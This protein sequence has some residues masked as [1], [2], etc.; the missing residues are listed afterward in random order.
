M[1]ERFTRFTQQLTIADND[2]RIIV[3]NP[4]VGAYTKAYAAY[5]E[6]LDRQKQADKEAGELFAAACVV[7]GSFLLGSIGNVSMQMIAKR[8]VAQ[9]AN[10]S[11][12][13]SYAN[14]F[15]I[16]RKNEGVAFAVGK[17]VDAATG[18][19]KFNAEKIATTYM[20]DVSSVISPE[21]LVQPRW[22]FRTRYGQRR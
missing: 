11:L 1:S 21:P 4:Y 13:K 10:S 17:F 16:V 15:C 3:G 14:V 2:W 8:T 22:S 20:Q 7:I 19:L 9:I 5:K 12:L 18:S 6:T